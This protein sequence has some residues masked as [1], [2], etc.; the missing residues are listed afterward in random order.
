MVQKTRLQ[1]ALGSAAQVSWVER[2]NCLKL[3]L[4][5]IGEGKVPIAQ[6]RISHHGPFKRIW[7]GY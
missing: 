3:K 7:Y 1:P 5:V 2:L 6:Q 4:F